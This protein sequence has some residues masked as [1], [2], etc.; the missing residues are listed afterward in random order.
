MAAAI[1]EPLGTQ[2]VKQFPA[3]R[4]IGPGAA[5]TASRPWSGSIR[6]RRWPEPL[7]LGGD[8]PR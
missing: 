4:R 7:G 5:R 2:A 1:W 3:R 8:G 6:R